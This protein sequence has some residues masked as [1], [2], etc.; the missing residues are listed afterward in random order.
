MTNNFKII[1]NYSNKKFDI[2]IFFI[3]LKT[4]IKSNTNFNLHNL[5]KPIKGNKI[6]DYRIRTRIDEKYIPQYFNNKIVFQSFKSFQQ[7]NFKLS[8]LIRKFTKNNIKTIAIQ[9]FGGE[10][11]L[12]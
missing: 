2:V 6:L 10:S 9:A 12:Y 4:M 5:L 7:K 3:I 1:N 11:F 8:K